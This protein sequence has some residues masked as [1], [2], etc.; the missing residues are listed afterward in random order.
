[1]NI[2]LE[3]G[4]TK[5]AIK[6]DTTK[7]A[8]YSL[9]SNPTLDWDRYARRLVLSEKISVAGIRTELTNE[10]TSVTWA[11][12]SEDQKI[13]WSKWGVATL[14]ERNTILSADDQ[15]KLLREVVLLELDVENKTHA[16][17]KANSLQTLTP[18]QIAGAKVSQI[19]FSDF[20]SGAIYTTT[21]SGFASLPIQ[22]MVPKSID[23]HPGKVA[24]GKIVVDYYLDNGVTGE[25]ELQNYTDLVSMAGTTFTLSTNGAWS[26]A[27]SNKF[28]LT[29]R[30]SYRIRSRRVTGN[31]NNKVYIEAATLI[32][33]YE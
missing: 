16:T 27:V 21:S 30:K 23:V 1:M 11:A 24:K 29:E 12:G 3:D 31:G 22:I 17:S 4:Q 25:V 10:Y 7:P 13:I 15:K 33:S 5:P 9:S 8:G 32:I 18:Q 28:T 6:L 19:K 20:A 2:Y 14:T 26:Y